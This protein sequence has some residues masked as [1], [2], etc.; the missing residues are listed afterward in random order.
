MKK[1]HTTRI[2]S[3]LK[4]S[5]FSFVNVFLLTEMVVMLSNVSP[6]S[7]ANLAITGGSLLGTNGAGTSYARG[8]HGSV[9][10]SGDDDFCGADEVIGRGGLTTNGEGAIR[11]EEEYKRFLEYTEFGK[12]SPYSETTSREVWSGNGMTRPAVS[13]APGTGFMGN[14]TGGRGNILPEAYGVYSF[15]TGCGAYASGNYSTA[16]GANS[17]ALTGGSQAFGVASLASGRVATAVG[18]GSEASGNSAIAL[19]GLTVA[20]GEHGVAIGTRAQAQGA[21]SIAIGGGEDE[22]SVIAAGEKSIAIGYHSSSKEDSSVALG[23]NATVLVTGGVAVGSGSVSRAEAGVSGYDPIGD[24]SSEN[25]TA[26][27][28]SSA[29]AFAVGDFGTSKSGTT[30]QIT[31]VAAGAQDTDAVNVAQLKA[32]REFATKKWRL[33]VNGE[34][35]TDIEEGN[36]VDFLVGSENLKIIES[37]DSNGLTFNL[38][39]EVTLDRINLGENVSLDETGL[40]ITG[41]PKIT[42]VGIDAGEKKI[43]NVATSTEDTDAVNFAQLKKTEQQLKDSYFIKQDAETEHLMIGAETGGDT[44]DV[45]NKNKEKRAI[46]GIKDGLLSETSSEA[47]T[48]SQLFAVKQELNTISGD[49]Q[50]TATSIAEFFGGDAKYE[51]GTWTAPTFKLKT[52]K[53]DGSSEDKTYDNLAEALAGVGSSFTNMQNSINDEITQKINDEVGNVRGESLV[54]KDK[55]TNLINIG[56]EVEGTEINIANSESNPRTLS[57][58]KAAVKADEVV[59]KGQLDASVKSV[60]DNLK[61]ESEKLTQSIESISTKVKGDALLWSA[62][63]SAFVADHGE[64]SSK[65]KSKIS[66]LLDG[67]IASGST[68]AITGGQLYSLNEQLA[69]YFGG[70]VEEGENGVWKAPSLTVHTVKEDGSSEDKTYDNVAEA[71]AGVGSS[72]TNMQNSI[73]DEIT[74]KINDEVGNVR[75]ESLVKKDKATNLISI[76]KEVE[77]TAIN[78]ANSESNPRTLS[79]VKAAVKADE[80]VNKGQLDASVKSV[81]DN[82]KEE[83]EKLAQSIESISTKVKGDSLLWSATD[84]AFVADHGEDSSKKKSKISHLLDGEIAS[85]STDAITGGQLYS[86]NEQLTTYFGGEVDGGENGVWKAPSLTVHTVKEDGSSED[87]TYDNVA[88]AL[89]GVGSSFTNMQNSI[90]DEITQKINDE[91]GN[92]RGESLVKKDKATNLIS[93]GKEVEGT[94]INIAN[95][96]SNPRTLSG[97]KAAVK[98]DEVVNKGQLDASVKSVSDNLKEESEKLAQSIESISTKVKGDSLLWSATDN[99][100]VADHG[101]DSSKKKSKISHLLDGEIASGSTDAITGGQLYSLNEQLATYLGGEVEEGENGVWKAPSLTVHTVKEDG[102]SE[103]KTYDNVAEALAGVGSSFTNMQNSIND[104]ITQK[105]NDE[106]GNVRGESLVKKDKATNLISIGKEVEGTAINIAN[107]ESNPRTLSGVKAAVKADEVVNKGQLDASVKSVSDNLKEESE[108]LAQSIESISTKVKGDSLLWSATD[109]AF[110]ADHGEDSSKK[111]SKISHLLDG[112]IASGSTDAITGG[113]LYSL[114]EQLTTYFGGEVEEGENGVW[115]AP[116]LTVHTV[117]EDGSSEDKTYDNVAE[118]LAGVGSSFTNMQNSI[119]DEITQKINDEVGNVRGESLVKKDK[120]TNLISIGKEVEGTAINIANSESNPRTLSGVKAAVKA[121]E[122]V[123]KGQLDASVKSVS[124]NLKEESEKLA[125]SIE[126]IST[127]VKGDSLLWSATDNAFVADHGEDSSKKK[128]KISHLLD[129]EIASGSTD[130]I[131]GGQLY[132]L[133]EQLTTYF[134]GEVDGGENGVWKAPSLTVHT[135]KEDGSSEDKTYDNVAEALAGVGSSFTNMQNSIN[136]EIT[137]KI[138]DEVGNVRGESLVKK[139]KATNLIS[140]GKEVEGTAINIANSESNPRTLSGVKAAVKADEVVNKGQLDASVKSVSDNLKEES[141][142]LAQSIESISTKVKGDSLLWSATDNA[143]VADHGEDSSK[144]KSKISHLLDGEIASGSTDAITGGQ[145]Y[146]LNEQLTTYFGGEVDGG[147]NGVWKAPSLT[148]HTVKEDGSSEDKT[149]DNVAEA[150]A[151]VGSSF[152]NMQNSINDEITQKINDEVGNVRGESLV[153]K[154][155]ATNLISIGKEVEGTAINIANSES[156]PRTLSGVKAAVKADE[157]V[158]KGQLDAS[159]KSVSDN[160]KE[161]SEKLAQ[162]I[163]SISTK[164][165]GDSLLWSATDNAFV[166][167]HGEDS[168]KKKSKISHLLDGEI[169]SGSTDAITG[170]QLYSLNEQLATYLGGEVEEGENGVWKAPSLTVHT[171]KEDGSSEDKTYDNVAEALAG[172]GSS[173]TNMQNSI[174]DEITQKINDEVGNVRGESLVKKDKATNLISIGKEVEGTAINIANSESNPRT[175]SGVKAAVKADEV[176]NKGQLD[177]SVKSVSDNLK[178]ESEKLAQ[179][180]ESISTK[181]KGDSLL[182]SATDNA[183]VADH[184]E[185]SSKKKSKISHLLDGEIASGSTDAITGGQLYSLNEQLTTYFGGE[186]DG[187]ENGVWKA[188]SLTVH[189]VKEDGSSE[190]KTYDNVAEA[191]AGVGSSFTNMQNSINDE[192]TQKI[193]DEVGNVRGESLVKKDKATNLISIGKEV[194][195][196][197]INIANSESNPRTLSGVKAAVKADE[198]VNK[199]QLDASVKSV[200]DNLKEES[201]KLAQSIESISTKVKGDSLLWSATDNAFVADHGEDSSKKKSKISHLLDGE[202][203]SGSTDAITGGQLYSLNEQLATYLGGEVEEGENGVW[204]APTFRV[205]VF[206]ADGTEAEESYTNLVSAFDGVNAAFTYLNKELT[207]EINKVVDGNIVKQDADTR[208]I[209]IGGDKSGTEVAFANIDGAARTLSGVKAGVL[210]ESSVEAVNGSQLYSMSNQLASYFGGG[211]GYKNGEWVAPIFKVVQLGSD[212]KAFEMKDYDS[213]SGAFEAVS[214]S[215]SSI[216]DR[217]SDVEKD[218]ASHALETNV[219]TWNEAEGAYD[220]SHGGADSKVTHVADGEVKQNSKEAVNGGQLWETNERVTAVENKVDTIDKQVQDIVEVADAV[221]AY[222]RNEDGKKKNSI[223][224]AGGDESAPVLIDN[225]KDGKIEEGSKEAVNGGQLH[226]FEESTKQQIDLILDD[227]KKYTDERLTNLLLTN[228]PMDGV[229]DDAKTY[230]DMQFELLN[231][232]IE[233]VQ[234]EARQAAAIGLAVSNLRYYDTPGSLSL[235]LAAGIWRSQSAFAIGAGYTSENGN[236]RSNLSITSAGGHW[237]IGAGITL[238]LR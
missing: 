221:V 149:Y 162:S 62:T 193:N 112:E 57:G 161:E 91:V 5:C 197:A 39:K 101:E 167:D 176:V 144:K 81:S 36:T 206:N 158:N 227:A 90:N 205:K 168:S 74:Q 13:G 19:G 105:I 203:A 138:N 219:V 23:A 175:L 60:S 1:L 47:V 18:V 126:S 25:G 122:V 222:D 46:S 70:E 208:V 174:N 102:S 148:V 180:I 184:G 128:S 201:E 164:V 63:D 230:T 215:L 225:V 56:K 117:K 35:L 53:D 194:E 98:A 61:E 214:G 76:G 88:E 114:N 150:L 16:F 80:V 29:G 30:R 130:A 235:S 157:V 216:N 59:N 123:N 10:F 140:I 129:G 115:K 131:T 154:D 106:V 223:T 6:V 183:F 169:A 195:G 26:A 155:K 99:A 77:G 71:L 178:E 9:V 54:K 40:V 212:G 185:D 103:D 192:I 127:K 42:T 187:G 79:G 93:I 151:G 95:S 86:L 38:A 119:N 234:K 209:S 107:S 224:L 49:L 11:V 94:A 51:D 31:G 3:S 196:T 84:N 141:E 199:G 188:P 236:V 27:W 92:V 163:E 124:D 171:V 108:K 211:A 120:A 116:S 200:S 237:G 173:F 198:V 182:W 186:V 139:D 17:T 132:S 89:A 75:G 41:G 8:S 73:N 213:V 14:T 22:S 238:R 210:S 67:E 166:A 232:G 160:L 50:T 220:V 43:T 233:D 207:N 20:K 113:Q 177:A 32:V 156:N 110:V 118:A 202:I 72:F 21:N 82:L 104:E 96:E 152:T 52:V 100:F 33:S 228:V 69:T 190:D 179:S 191:L 66:H 37:E 165:K 172:V 4:S 12:Y 229:L 28:K 2:A 217:I 55:E 226:D 147:E 231:D 170:G 204:K 87:K 146:S 15:V 189:T 111:K 137:Q 58:V 125:Q 48:G 68:D 142:K 134:G 218:V 181:V 65:K 136:D 121:D 97:V 45:S 159:V 83:S 24:N 143:F 133:N 34:E 85:G 7:A 64:D 153:K 109:N 44:V 78:I 145:L 135:V